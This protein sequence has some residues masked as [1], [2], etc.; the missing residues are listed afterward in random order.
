MLAPPDL[1]TRAENIWR[2]P[3]VPFAYQ[4]RVL[5]MSIH[6]LFIAYG[7]ALDKTRKLYRFNNCLVCL[8]VCHCVPVAAITVNNPSINVVYNLSKCV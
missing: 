6:S 3:Q 2:K 8:F 4:F 1:V 7:S 5:L